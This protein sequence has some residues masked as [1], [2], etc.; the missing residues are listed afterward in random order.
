MALAQPNLYFIN[1]AKNKIIEVKPSQQLSIKYKGYLGQPEFVK[2]TVTDINDSMITLG[3]DPQLLGGLG[4]ALE[5][6]PKF[7]YRK[8]RIADIL[9][10]RRMTK[11]RQILKVGLQLAN[12]VAS[13][14]LLA[15]LYSNTGLSPASTFAIS[16]G[17]GIS[18]NI[19]INTALPE[20]PKYRLEDG[21]EVTTGNVM[22]KL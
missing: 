16:L 20:N 18:T 22:P 21:W 17:V 13:Y 2:Q 1:R 5:N 10:F 8:V 4:K 9:T 11:G 6:N 15:N 3:V 7:V 14:F 19:I 12:I